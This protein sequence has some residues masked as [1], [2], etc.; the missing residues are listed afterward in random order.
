MREQRLVREH[1]RKPGTRADRRVHVD[2]LGVADPHRE[3]AL[4]PGQVSDGD[5]LERHACGS[6]DSERPASV[7]PRSDIRRRNVLESADQKRLAPKRRGC[8]RHLLQADD[9]RRLGDD[10]GRLFG[11][12][13]QAAGDIPADEDQCAG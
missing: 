3:H 12:P 6:Q 2:D 13:L 11:Q 4:R 1:L 9:V 5:G 7:R 8:L 10:A